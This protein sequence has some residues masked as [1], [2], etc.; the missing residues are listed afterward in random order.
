[1]MARSIIL[2]KSLSPLARPL[3]NR[4]FRQLHQNNF[5]YFHLLS[6]VRDFD[7]S[8]SGTNRSLL[9]QS[10]S[11]QYLFTFILIMKEIRRRYTVGCQ[12]DRRYHFLS[13][14]LSQSKTTFKLES[15]LIYILA[16]SSSSKGQLMLFLCESDE[17]ELILWIL[18]SN[19][20]S[21]GRAWKCSSSSCLE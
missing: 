13:L 15:D 11:W 20:L 16:F 19:D 7:I 4:N 6:I 21:L 8:V 10:H 2:E 1:M 3:S 12:D 17:K 18:S 5:T 9:K 14:E